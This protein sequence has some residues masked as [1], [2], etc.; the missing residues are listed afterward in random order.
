MTD[1]SLR[2]HLLRLVLLPIAGVLAVGSVAA[3]YLAL[4][5][6]TAA[7]DASLVDTGLALAER[8]RIAGNVTTADVPPG[9]EQVLR[10]D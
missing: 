5:P 2:G 9:V 10:T 3:Y 6:A 1:R 4:E 7:H 8:I